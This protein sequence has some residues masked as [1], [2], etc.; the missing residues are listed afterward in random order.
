MPVDIP[1][2]A[3]TSPGV[4]A[5]AANLSDIGQLTNGTCR[6]LYIGVSGDVK[7]AMANGD[8]IVF[9]N[10]PVGVL[11]VSVKQVFNNLT[12]ASGIIAIY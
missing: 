4:G 6:S 10:V 7:V 3:S 12:T 2:E 8:A 5:T 11:P 1:F 9:A